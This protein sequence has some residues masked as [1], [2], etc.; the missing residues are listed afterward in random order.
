[1]E[2]KYKVLLCFTNKVPFFLRSS[3]SMVGAGNIYPGTIT[4]GQDSIL[5]SQTG[6]MWDS[7]QKNSQEEVLIAYKD[8]D[9]YSR[10]VSDIYLMHHNPELP[11]IIMIEA[12]VVSWIFP[13]KKLNKIQRALESHSIQRTSEDKNNWKFANKTLIYATIFAIVLLVALEIIFK[14][15]KR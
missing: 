12:G 14:A 2:E 7:F 3:F 4:F 1:M 10:S 15:T 9:S 5:L 13:S 11:K 8:I 6:K